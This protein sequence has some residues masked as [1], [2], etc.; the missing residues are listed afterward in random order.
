MPGTQDTRSFTVEGHAFHIYRSD[1]ASG[2]LAFW[3]G[4]RDGDYV[5]ADDPRLDVLA[6]AVAGI[7]GLSQRWIGYGASTRELVEILERRML[8]LAGSYDSI[9]REV[10]GDLAAARGALAVARAPMITRNVYI[11]GGAFS[12]DLNLPLDGDA[13][14]T[15]AAYGLPVGTFIEQTLAELGAPIER[16]PGPGYDPNG[17]YRIPAPVVTAILDRALVANQ[18]SDVRLFDRP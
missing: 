8:E 17:H 15:M 2:E 3:G 16:V 7:A 13:I 5:T 10:H 1:A 6:R 11:S 9:G 4:G 12:I 14:V 18:A